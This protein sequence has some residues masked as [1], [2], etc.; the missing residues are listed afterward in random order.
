[1]TFGCDRSPLLLHGKSA[2]GEKNPIVERAVQN[3]AL[4][5]T[6]RDDMT[7]VG[8]ARAVGRTGRDCGPLPARSI[9]TC[10]CSAR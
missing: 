6:C 9:V 5:T 4:L 8:A 10:T 7:G 2:V 1:M 3:L